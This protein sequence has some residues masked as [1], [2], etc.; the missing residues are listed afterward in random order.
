MTAEEAVQKL[1]ED[2]V[3]AK[4]QER[5]GRE[6]V[7]ITTRGAARG[8]LLEIERLRDQVKNPQFYAKPRT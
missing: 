4:T 1:T 3:F 8:V 5:D 7:V 2:V 6:C